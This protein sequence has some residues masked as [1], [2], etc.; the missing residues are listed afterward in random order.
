MLRYILGNR[1]VKQYKSSTKRRT[2][3]KQVA[4][5]S[6]LCALILL[7]TV[8]IG[9]AAPNWWRFLP[10]PIILPVDS[11]SIGSS[12]NIAAIDF[13]KYLPRP[14]VLPA[15]SSGYSQQIELAALPAPKNPPFPWLKKTVT[16]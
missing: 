3:M 13:K 8:S 7:G 11:V 16:A 12:I 9:H 4:I 2:K 10:K 15:D 6:V 1:I 14:I 5:L